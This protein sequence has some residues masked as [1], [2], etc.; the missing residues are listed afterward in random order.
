[1]PKTLDLKGKKFW[2][3]FVIER[4]EN[5]RCGKSQWLCQCDC[6]KR[7]VVIGANLK[8][9]NTRSCGCW[10]HSDDKSEYTGYIWRTRLYS[11]WTDM[12][13]RC[14]NKNF[15]KYISYGNR[16]IKICDEW[17]TY[18]NF[19]NWAVANS[20][21][22][23]LTIDRIDVNGNYEPSNCRWITNK[24]QARNKTNAIMLTYKGKTKQLIEWCEELQL[25]YVAV[26]TR[27]IRGW[28]PEAILET[29]VRK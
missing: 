2:K 20:Y 14:Y 3:L 17:R 23:D 13:S 5:S 21:S 9:G 10:V 6:G 11:I 15:P 8:N 18:E 19:E 1:M 7:L 29:P 4:A 16:E 22:D 26:Y 24:E 28:E 27:F 25:S 12:K